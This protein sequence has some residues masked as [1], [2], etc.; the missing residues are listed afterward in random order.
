MRTPMI[1]A[2]WKMHKTIGEAAAFI[3]AFKPRVDGLQ[4]VEV[5]ICPA[6]T[7]LGTVG[8]LLLGTRIAL[9]AQNMFREP[10]GAFTG[11]VSPLMLKDLGV[12][13]VIIGHSERRQYFAEDDALVNAKVQSAFR[14]GLTPILC[15][16]ESLAERD[17]GRTEAVVA[18][19]VEAA[20]AGLT[21]EQA[22]A[23][24]IAYEPVWAIGSGR[25]PTAA[26]ANQVCALVRSRVAA[27]FGEAAGAAVRV[28]YGGSV[29]PDNIGEFMRQPDIDGALVGGASLDPAGFATLIANAAAL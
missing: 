3:E 9:G 20:T 22:A 10:Q 26:D 16:G 29:K 25:T 12:R 17:A 28:Q 23:L 4:A 27:A 15:V 6:F 5:A 8:R 21:A 14:H 2:N 18:G 7:A 1:A 13:Y 19:Q 24:V 11:E